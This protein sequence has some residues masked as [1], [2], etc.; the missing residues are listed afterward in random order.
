LYDGQPLSLAQEQDALLLNPN[1]PRHLYDLSKACGEAACLGLGGGKARVARLS[2]VYRNE[3]D[4]DGF[5][6]QIF[7]Q[8]L[9][10]KSLGKMNA[11]K[12]LSWDTAPDLERDYVHLD[13]VVQALLAIALHGQQLIYNVAS[14]ENISNQQLFDEIFRVTGVCP[15]TTRPAQGLPSAARIDI[16]SLRGDLACNPRKLIASIEQLWEQA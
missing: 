12:T 6:G 15:V 16:Q 7:R 11:A 3:H 5:L 4:P 9:P 10:F 2:C 13:D 14:G 8:L 1:N